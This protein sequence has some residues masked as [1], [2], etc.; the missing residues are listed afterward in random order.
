MGSTLNVYGR[1]VLG[2]IKKPAPGPVP[3][4]TLTRTVT[5]DPDAV[6]QFNTVT[7]LPV[8]NN[9]PAPYL[10]TLGFGPSL[11]LMTAPDF[12][13]PVL[14]MVHVYNRFTQHARVPMG[15][16]VTLQISVSRPRARDAGSELDVIVH[17]TV[18][19]ETVFEDVSTYFAK[20]TKLPEADEPAPARRLD[21]PDGSAVAT[22]KFPAGLGE[23]YARVSGDYNVIHLNSLAAR[24]F[25][26]PGRL[27]TACSRPV[28]RL[29]SRAWL[30]RRSCGMCSSLNR[31][32]CPAEQKF[33]STEPMASGW[34]SSGQRMVLPTW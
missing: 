11:E 21:L 8:N 20:K 29:R 27:R 18:D 32:C 34:A 24:A 10:H 26:F 30:P 25:G 16:E 6:A 15:A 12:P 31:F 13:V 7:G 5:I 22:W 2:A 17:G 9:V 28:R 14:G 3:T 23:R 4:R 1:A 19:G 33:W